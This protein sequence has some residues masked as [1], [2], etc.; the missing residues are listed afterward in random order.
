MVAIS[1]I[2]MANLAVLYSLNT[3]SRFLKS[4]DSTKSDSLRNEPDLTDF[5]TKMVALALL[6]SLYTQDWEKILKLMDLSSTEKR[7]TKEKR[8]INRGP[9]HRW[10]RPCCLALH[11]L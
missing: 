7:L 1:K 8:H 6:Y 5:K 9:G 11:L 10:R 3:Q 4:A 2:K